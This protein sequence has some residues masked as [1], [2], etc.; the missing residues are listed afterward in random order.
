MGYSRLLLAYTPLRALRDLPIK[1][2]QITCSAH[3]SCDERQRR[4]V[5]RVTTARCAK[6]KRVS[7]GRLFPSSS[8]AFTKPMHESTTR[9]RKA[10]SRTHEY[11]IVE[12]TR[13]VR[14]FCSPFCST[15]TFTRFANDNRQTG[16]K[17]LRESSNSFCQLS[18]FPPYLLCTRCAHHFS[19]SARESN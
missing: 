19:R 1:L 14:T 3:P 9:K 18:Y 6:A 7:L 16:D 10:S 4:A 8:F 15:Y 11:D 5:A 13:Y 2:L 12:H 17:S